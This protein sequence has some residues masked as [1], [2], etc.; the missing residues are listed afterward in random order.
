MGTGRQPSGYDVIV[1]GAGV[2]GLSCG[3]RAAQAGSS[4]LVVD[5]DEPGSGASGV[6][7]GMLAPVTEAEFGEETLLRLLLEA[8]PLW[9]AFDA[10]LS[11]R[12]G[13]DTGY[14][15]SGALVVAPDRDELAEVRRL[16]E[17][18]RSLGLEVQWLSG[19]ECRRLEPGLSPRVGGGVHAPHDHQVDPG[20]TVAA[21]AAAF[22][23]EGGDLRTGTE[24]LELLGDGRVTGIRTREGVLEADQVVIAAGSWSAALN[25]IPEELRPPVRPVKGQILTL[26]GPRDRA[27]ATRLVRTP[28]CYVVCRADG[29]VVIGA[30]VEERGWD[31]RV[32]GEGIYRLLDAA[33]EVLPDVL[34]LEWVGARS[35]L[36]PGTPDNAP[37]VGRS[38]LDGLLWAT[39]HY[40][41]GVLLAPLTGAAVAGVL[42]G[43][44]LPAALV[45]FGPER[46]GRRARARVAGGAA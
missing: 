19:R 4:V 5:R 37:V 2:I 1:V 20:A 35:G 9:E 36:R 31:T 34:E 21:L 15:Q 28:S 38:S 32:T 11:E 14:R 10:E 33:W 27:L 17:F 13:L 6:A 39:G 23:A 29:R 12:S 46:F 7:A 24:V 42:A 16:H 18:Q 41:N 25:G 44:P 22:E 30:T 40:R 26:R 8:A 45:P 3:W 43:A